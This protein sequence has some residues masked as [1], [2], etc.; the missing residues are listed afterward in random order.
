MEPE[1]KLCAIITGRGHDAAL[2]QVQRARELGAGLVELRMDLI[3]GNSLDVGKLT[4]K[5]HS[6][7]FTCI[8]T[9]RDKEEGGKYEGKGKEQLMLDAIKSG[10]DFVDVELGRTGTIE[11]VKA[12]ARRAGCKI[13]ASWHGFGKQPAL[14]KMEEKIKEAKSAGAD[15][16]KVAFV[17]EK[18][19][20]KKA[21]DGLFL[22]A[23]KNGIALIASPMGDCALEGRAYALSKG[24]PFA[25]CTLGPDESVASGV[26]A[27]GQLR[28]AVAGQTV[29]C[30]R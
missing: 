8:V 10:A 25:Y 1:G 14:S 17:A 19:E 13:I 21:I 30:E 29:K 23:G 2:L 15:V 26:P 27:I 18:N 4:R 20:W 22:A 16:A 6:L 11:A 3:L 12:G 7:G 28:K 24:S 5:A 9:W